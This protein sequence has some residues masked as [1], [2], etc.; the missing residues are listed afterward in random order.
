MYLRHKA[1]L[2]SIMLAHFR[3]QKK[4]AFLPSTMV[5]PVSHTQVFLLWF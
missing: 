3:Q 1:H 5:F 4:T 2:H